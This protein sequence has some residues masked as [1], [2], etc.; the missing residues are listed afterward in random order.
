MFPELAIADAGRI[1]D[2][3]LRGRILRFHAPNLGGSGTTTV[4]FTDT[5]NDGVF[6]SIEQG[7]KSDLV[8]QGIYGLL[9]WDMLYR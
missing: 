3:S 1:L 6:D 7:T 5:D 4:Y 2:H 9:Y 8:A